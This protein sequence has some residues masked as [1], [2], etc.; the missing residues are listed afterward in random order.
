MGMRI[1]LRYWEMKSNAALPFD[2]NVQVPK[3]VSLGGNE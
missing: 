3:C 2:L 1:A